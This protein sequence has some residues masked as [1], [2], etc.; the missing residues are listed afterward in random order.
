MSAVRLPR[1]ATW[2]V[3]S[4]YGEGLKARHAAPAH[5][6]VHGH[7][8]RFNAWRQRRQRHGQARRQR[9]A[10]ANTSRRTWYWCA[11]PQCPQPAATCCIN[12]VT[13]F[14]GA[15]AHPSP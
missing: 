6:N 3:G 4:P 15:L 14:Q 1:M 2:L 5:N 8:M 9:H 10:S 11:Y 7:R 13:T 12:T